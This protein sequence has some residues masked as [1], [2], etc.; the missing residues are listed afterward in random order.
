[1]PP[2]WCRRLSDAEV[3]VKKAS[4]R[5]VAK[6]TPS[7]A[8][9][10]R[11]ETSLRAAKAARAR[12]AKALKA[13]TDELR[14]A[15]EQQTATSDVLGVIAASPACASSTPRSCPLSSQATPMRRRS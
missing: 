7:A 2:A 15:L 14:E 9:L 11:L 10:A 8:E 1:M 6:K 12:L 5:K 3:K 4:K 13:R